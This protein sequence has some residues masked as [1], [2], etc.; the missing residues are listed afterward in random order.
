[1]GQGQE[2]KGRPT[3]LLQVKRHH[4]NVSNMLATCRHDCVHLGHAGEGVT[5]H[6]QTGKLARTEPHCSSERRKRRRDDGYRENSP[7]SSWALVLS[8]GRLSEA[9]LTCAELAACF[10]S[11]AAWC[12]PEAFCVGARWR[13]S[14]AVS[15]AIMHGCHVH[16]T[17]HCL[18]QRECCYTQVHNTQRFQ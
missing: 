15:S 10:P 11:V 16:S 13:L 3:H 9:G 4:N 1:M 2:L 5:Q 7:L 18:Q 12:T 6:Q 14:C 17:Q 8:H